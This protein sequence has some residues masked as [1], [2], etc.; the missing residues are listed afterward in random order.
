MWISIPEPAPPPM[1]LDAGATATSAAM[2]SAGYDWLATD[3][4]FIAFDPAGDGRLIEV[5]GSLASARRVAV[6]VPGSDTNLSTY[7][8]GLAVKARQLY[9]E[10]MAEDPS[11]RVAVVAWLGYDTPDG[12]GLAAVREDRAA[13]GAAE[14]ERFV[15]TLP[16]T[17]EV[18]L[19]GHSYGTVVVSLALPSLAARVTDAVFLASPGLPVAPPAGVRTWS[20][21]A[22]SDW[23][24]RVPKIRIVGLGH[25]D[26]P[27][28]TALPVGE[29]TGHDGYFT[30]PS[31]LEAMAGV[32]RGG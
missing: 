24:N 3:R 2:R 15:S 8:R 19:I 1:R 10:L 7:D 29:V 5:F 27:S 18:V 12:L 25:G 17:A 28:F 26:A 23:V 20:A 16:S 6:I 9:G 11:A 31:T 4:Q 14:L 21:T 22:T 32:V 30:A 13:A